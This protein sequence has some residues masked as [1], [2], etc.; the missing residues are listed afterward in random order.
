MTNEQYLIDALRSLVRNVDEDVP[1]EYRSR[2]L[3]DA[4]AL[5]FE[6]IEGF[7]ELPIRQS[8]ITEPLIPCACELEVAEWH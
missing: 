6:L 3:N 4:M 5:A 1:M 7:E 2:H 8:V